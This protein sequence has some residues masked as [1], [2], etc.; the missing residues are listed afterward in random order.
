[1]SARKIYIFVS[2]FVIAVITAL[3]YF[4]KY[5]LLLFIFF[6]PLILMGMYDMLQKKKA[7]LRNF[8][9]IGNLRYFMESIRP[10]IQQYFVESN[11]S[12]RP[13]N[14]E[15]RSIVYQRAKGALQTLPFGTQYDVYK[16]GYEWAIHSLNPKEVDCHRLRVVIGGK[17]CSQPYTAQILNIS[18]MSYGSL[19]KNAILAFNKGA[20]MGGFYH[21]T[22]EGGISPY[23]LKNGGDLVWQVGTGY[24]GCRYKDGSFDE[25]TY[26]HNAQRPEVKMI[27]LKLS[28]GAKPGHGGILPGV[29]VTEE[30]ARIRLVEPHKDVVSPPKHSAFDGPK[31]LLEF[32][33]K[34]RYL[35]GGKPV[36]M[37]ICVGSTSEFS[38]ICRA[39][40]ETNIYPDFI[41]VDGGE[42]GTG[43]A[44]LEFA[45]HLGLPLYEGLCFVHNE[46]VRNHLRDK[47]KLIASGKILTAFQMIKVMA[48]GADI[49]NSARGMMLAVGCIHALRCNSNR[50]P[51]GV[52]TN[53][54]NLII[55]LDPED[56]GH[57]V[58]R[59]QKD[60][61]KAFAELLGAI[62]LEHP[63]QLNREHLFRRVS[64]TEVKSFAEIYKTAIG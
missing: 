58:Y 16:E 10:E 54:P 62:G 61:V 1:M 14:R 41:T 30:I 60:T 57:R 12:G 7:V 37:K 43:A 24:F 40:V 4:S 48:L 27:E 19:S 20:K 21:N 38:D 25:K 35:S 53:N 15:L 55:G 32:I 2:L 46:L 28:Q 23:H 52:T 50:C 11:H 3:S 17:D 34:L 63:S 51:T 31:G 9:V 6:V 44:P 26:T 13:I 29:K 49:V 47:I 64:S 45:N 59:F 22:G 18:A 8:P 36:G 33:Q 42:G 5:Y 56:K 39:I